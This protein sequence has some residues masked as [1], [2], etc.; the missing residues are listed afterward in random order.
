MSLEN[1][2]Y[3]GH[4]G[5]FVKAGD[6]T[7]AIDPW[8]TGNPTYPSE[9]SNPEKIDLIILTHGHADHAGDAV[10]LSK[11]YGSKIVCI[12]DL[13]QIL[14]S[15]GT[16]ADN[17]IGMNKGGKVKID[18]LTIA[19]T[20][21]FHSNSYTKADGQT[22]YAG[23]ACGV[24][25]SDGKNTIFHAGDTCLFSDMSLIAK[26]FKPQIALL[27]IGDYFTMDAEDAAEAA[28]LLG[29]SKA[30]PI[31]YKTFPL[32]TQ[33]ANEFTSKLDRF[34]IECVELEP[35]QSHNL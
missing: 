8:M 15:E 1:I 11:E 25:L 13:G 35:G 32:L 3:L 2:T 30:I 7:I 23:E 6:K 33:S 34:G 14:I 20:N 21:A 9:L 22:V 17:V 18:E 19:L 12:Y 5:A 24:I 26:K 28:F 31:H 29:V 10:R 16:P 4:S 27:P